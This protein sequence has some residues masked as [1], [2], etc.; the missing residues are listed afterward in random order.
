VPHCRQNRPVSGVSEL[1][2]GHFIAIFASVALAAKIY[3]AGSTTTAVPYASTSVTPFI[4][5]HAS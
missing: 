2:L 5:S 1:H 3:F 4:T